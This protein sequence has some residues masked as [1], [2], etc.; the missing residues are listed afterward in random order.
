MTN[1]ITNL[2]PQALMKIHLRISKYE[3]WNAGVQPKQISSSRGVSFTRA[4]GSP[5]ISRPWDS[6]YA[7]AC[8]AKHAYRSIRKPRIRELR[9]LNPKPVTLDRYLWQSPCGPGNSTPSSWESAWVKLWKAELRFL[10]G[11]SCLFTRSSSISPES[12]RNF[13]GIVRIGAP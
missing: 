12:H 5:R 8:C 6:G 3:W 11:V 10:G 4:R 9:S 2:K 13:T 7:N 1:T